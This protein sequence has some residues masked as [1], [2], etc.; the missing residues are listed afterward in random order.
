MIVKL[1]HLD[2]KIKVKQSFT[3]N[4]SYLKYLHTKRQPE[5]RKQGWDNYGYEVKKFLP[6]FNVLSEPYFELLAE[7]TIC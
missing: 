1:E 2:R 3:G 6:H 7:I 4:K 5:T